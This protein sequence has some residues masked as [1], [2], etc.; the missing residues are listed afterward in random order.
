MSELG[1][2][3]A[4]EAKKHAGEKEEPPGSDNTVYGRWAAEH[5][6]HNRVAGCGNFCS[7][8]VS[9]ASNG[10]R[11]VGEGTP[12]PADGFVDSGLD[13]GIYGLDGIVF[14][15]DHAPTIERWGRG[16]HHAK[17]LWVESDYEP[18]DILCIAVPKKG[19]DVLEQHSRH[20]CVFLHY[21]EDGT[22]A[23]SLDGNYSNAV[24][25]VERDADSEEILGGIRFLTQ[26]G[27]A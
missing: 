7:M 17:V 21:N 27:A 6:G 4:A 19:E 14:G 11:A 13:G 15:C 16:R 26:D 2:R 20:V 22:K 23:V 24:T 8:C 3:I 10:E 18:G 12:L 9:L 25:R 5:G 1:D